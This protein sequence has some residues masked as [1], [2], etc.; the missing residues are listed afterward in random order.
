M[1]SSLCMDVNAEPMILNQ[2]RSAKAAHVAKS[3]TV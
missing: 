3:Y 1:C 2:H